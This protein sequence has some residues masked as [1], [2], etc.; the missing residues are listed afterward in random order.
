MPVGGSVSASA[1][2]KEAGAR[3]RWSLVIASVVM[4]V[5]IVRLRRH[6]RVD[7]HARARRTADPVGVR[8]IKPDNLTSV[9]R[10]GPVQKT[11]LAVTF[12]LTMVIP[13]QYAVLAGVGLSVLLHVSASPTR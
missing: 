8:T 4:A 5:V 13:L 9:W 3:S 11:V 10:T 2:N 7:R 1:L 12:V 6:R